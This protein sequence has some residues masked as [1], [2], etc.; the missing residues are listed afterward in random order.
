MAIKVYRL[1]KDL[2]EPIRPVIWP[3]GFT[4]ARF[5]PEHHADPVY[6]L[7][8]EGY[9]QGG[10]RV[11]DRQTWW[12]ALSRDAEY[13]PDLIFLATDIDDEVKGVAQ[14]WTSAFVK[15]LVVAPDMR[16]RG[17]ATGLLNLVF[18]HFRR[19][20]S[21]FVD[22]KVDAGNAPAL[23]FYQAEGMKVVETTMSD[24]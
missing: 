16:R 6:G 1:R 23:A 21:P 2:S 3:A 20:G 13:D 19:R 7:L 9:S 22:L 8:K 24:Q 10:G 5:R 14:C 4:N 11:A 18:D 12:Q 15:D 17:V